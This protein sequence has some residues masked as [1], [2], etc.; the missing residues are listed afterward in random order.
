MKRIL[1]GGDVSKGYADFIGIDED[2][3]EKLANKQFADS[4][5]GH[6][7]LGKCLL[8]ILEDEDCEIYCGV[9]STGGYENNWFRFLQ[10]ISNRIYVTRINPKAVKS[11]GEAELVRTTTDA[12]SAKMIAT[13]LLRFGKKLAYFNK[14][15]QASERCYEGRKF[16]KFIGRLLK[17]QTA[18]RN[19]LEKT[20]YD[21]F[22]SALSICKGKCAN[23]LLKVLSRYSSQQKVL[24]AGISRISKL[25]GVTEKQARNLVEGVKRRGKQC[26]STVSHLIASQCQQILR[27][28]REI[29]EHKK[30]L[31]KTYR[32]LP[33][34]QFLQSVPGIG[35]QSAVEL[36][37]EIESISRFKSAKKLCSYFGVHPIFKQSGDGVGK[38]RMSKKGRSAVRRILF[39]C[40]LTSLRWSPMFR[41]IY[42]KHRQK[43]KNHYQAM[44]VIMH[45]MLRVVWALLT[46][47]RIFD[48]QADAAL[49]GQAQKQRESQKLASQAV[50]EVLDDDAPISARKA[51][52]LKI[53]AD[54][55]I[56]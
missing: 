36:L 2:L 41:K 14:S 23:W 20:L 12:V 6:E 28:N 48:E 19:T 52:K 21:F 40:C 38:I 25:K 24:K 34:V 47:G 50:V 5:S 35:I 4:P 45:K 13:Y 9:E 31:I 46:Y 15:H 22:P 18:H 27:L 1:L 54:V 43:G 29:K 39:M 42:A 30:L 55:P 3:C 17:D 32:D 16:N 8:S 26:S 44:G 37:L 33:G 10:S 49:C 51:K 56:E 7:Q 11:N 53:Q